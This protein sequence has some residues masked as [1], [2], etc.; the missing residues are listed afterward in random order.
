M[1][2]LFKYITWP[3][4][5]LF[6]LIRRFLSELLLGLLGLVGYDTSKKLEVYFANRKLIQKKA[7]LI[8]AGSGKFKKGDEVDYIIKN[9]KTK[10]ISKSA[11]VVQDQL[12]YVAQII[13]KGEDK[14]QFV[15]VTRLKHLT[16][17][18]PKSNNKINGNSHHK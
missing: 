16:V 11:I 2:K 6:K 3:F 12:K 8:Q 18:R 17:I 15:P 14:T 9:G 7:S 5:K 13:V 10:K 1:R 4:V